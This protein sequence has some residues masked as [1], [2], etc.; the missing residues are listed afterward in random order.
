MTPVWVF[1]AYPLLLAA[2][3]ATNLIGAAERAGFHSNI[4]T[5]AVAMAA[6]AMQGTGYLISFMVSASFLYRLMTQKLP[7]DPRRPGVVSYMTAP[8]QQSKAR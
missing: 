5:L 7:R 1:P 6:V 2:P 3:F 4:N 8:Q